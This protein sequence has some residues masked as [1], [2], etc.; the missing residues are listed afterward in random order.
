MGVSNVLIQPVFFLSIYYILTDQCLGQ[1][2]G[3]VAEGKKE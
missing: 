2:S 1:V 3:L